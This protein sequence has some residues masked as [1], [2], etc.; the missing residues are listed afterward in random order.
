MKE[1]RVSKIAC[2]ILI[3]AFT[4]VACG[5]ENSD[6]SPS[7]EA[8]AEAV[9]SPL[10][11]EEAGEVSYGRTRVQWREQ[12]FESASAGPIAWAADTFVA[13]SIHSDR[14]SE[15]V[16]KQIEQNG[17]DGAIGLYDE[18]DW[19]E[20]EIEVEQTGLYELSIDYFAL[21]G[22]FGP[23]QIGVQIDGQYPYKEAKS[24]GL[25]RMWKD[26]SF[27]LAKDENGNEIRS[28]QEE[29]A[30]WQSVVVS[31]SSAAYAEPLLWLL[32]E[33]THRLRI[34]TIYDPVLLS[35]LAFSAPTET[36]PYAEQAGI[37]VGGEAMEGDWH[38]LIEAERMWRKSDSS[39]QMTAS[40]DELASPESN[41]KIVFNT[42]GGDRWKRGGQWAEWQFEVPAD[43]YYHIHLKYSQ[44]YRTDAA[45]FRNMMLNGRYPFREMQAYPF[46]YTPNWKLE[47]LGSDSGEAYLFYMKAGRNT[48]RL[49]ATY[50]PLQGI[51]ESMQAAVSQIQTLNREVRLVTGV[52]DPLLGDANRDWNLLLYIPDI[53]E[54]YEDLIRQLEMQLEG[55]ESL[56]GRKISGSDGIRSGISDLKKL[57]ANPNLLPKRPEMLASIQETLSGFMTEL[58][59]QP[60][61]LDLI[62]IARPEAELPG[63]I[64]NWGDRL[65]N[66]IKGFFHT[67]SSEYSYYGREDEDAIT[68]WVNRGRDYVNLLQ[69]MVDEQFTPETGIRVNINLMPNPQQL[70][71]SHAAGR[72]PDAALGI[73]PGTIVDFAMRNAAVDLSRFPDYEEAAK[74]YSPGMRVQLYYNGGNYGLPETVSPNM[75]FIRDDLFQ[76]IGIEP[77]QTWSDVYAILPDLQQRG[78]DFFYSHTNYLP[79]VFQNGAEFFTP[80]GMR[81]GLDTP[82]GF[83]AFK[84]WTDLFKVFGFPREVPNFYMHFRNGDMPIGI[85]DFNTYLQLLVA[86]PEIA[87]L[88]SVYPIPGMENEGTVER[89]AGGAIQGGMIFKTSERQ[90]E[91]W[92]FIKWWASEEVQSRYGNEIELLNGTEFRW[93]TANVQA[94]KRLPWPKEDAAA[95]FEQMSWFKEMPIVPGFYFTPREL[96]FAWNR[97]VLSDE[98]Y[99]ESLEASI[100]EINREMRRKLHEFGLVDEQG[101]RLRSLEIPQVNEKWEGRDEP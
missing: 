100:L 92:K 5:G 97:S 68:V 25:N 78:Y 96:N 88:W 80:D 20:Y 36:L 16:L 12:G 55:L 39:L 46:D 34:Q 40:M 22:S 13:S 85:A 56:Y 81:S 32:E 95:I 45:V 50:A 4:V 15:T 72:E 26:G 30:G 63:V 70:I 51:L 17:K 3:F 49:E 54:R 38:T 2:L 6:G 101:N 27:P 65:G 33:G 47:T 11:Q 58:R 52:R 98:N 1:R 23:I 73:D 57:K 75:M 18:L 10:V 93:N 99:R 90:E 24:I 8:A 66:T 37:P 77:P 9:S 53:V 60:L 84:Q 14:L 79:F 48:L 76:A 71:L 28:V 94:L 29:I 61:D 83:A 43:G 21:K 41:G 87:G 67:F 91:T 42:I 31:D 59:E 62:L 7:A 35:R 44:G 64:P 82:E 69:Q 74:D 86:A 89:W 19:A